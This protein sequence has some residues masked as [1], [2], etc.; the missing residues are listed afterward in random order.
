[1]EV[2]DAVKEALKSMI[3]P[4]LAQLKA[5]IGTVKTD[6]AKVTGQLDVTNH[7]IGD[8]HDEQM[9][10]RQEMTAGFTRVD[11]RFE[12]V[13]Q[14]FEHVDQRFE[15]VD[16][17]FDEMR[18][19]TDAKFE[20]V[21]QRFD[22]MSQDIDAKFERVDQRF[23]E[24]RRETDAKF[25]RVD[26]HFDGMRRDFA[27]SFDGMSHDSHAKLERIHARIDSLYLL[28]IKPDEFAIVRQRLDG[29]EREVK[30]LKKAAGL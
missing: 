10:L 18:R 30:D 1:M 5:D 11:Q 8:L 6:L 17:R 7:R 29:L 23:D 27:A 15:R 16:Q 20:R 22:E 14:R 4:E 12:H 21:D 2:L 9:L 3:L 19:E 24:M 28:M 13:D 25:E 26:Q